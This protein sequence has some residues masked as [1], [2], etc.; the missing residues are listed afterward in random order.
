MMKKLIFLLFLIQTFAFGADLSHKKYLEDIDSLEEIFRYYCISYEAIQKSGRFDIDKKIQELR[1]RNVK[2]LNSDDFFS[3]LCGAFENIPDHHISFSFLGETYLLRRKELKTLGKTQPLLL[4][5]ER[6]LYFSFSDFDSE[7]SWKNVRK[8]ENLNMSDFDKI[9]FDLRGNSGGDFE[10]G[11]VILKKLCGL[12]YEDS[13]RFAIC[14]KCLLY[15]DSPYYSELKNM[16]E[17][18][19]KEMKKIEKGDVLLKRN[20]FSRN[21]LHINKSD[22]AFTGK[23]FVLLDGLTASSAEVFAILLRQNFKNIKLLGTE[24]FG[25]YSYGGVLPA[26]LPNS[27]IIINIP[28]FQTLPGVLQKDNLDPDDGIQPD[29]QTESIGA[30]LLALAE[31]G[32]SEEIIE[33]ISGNMKQT[34]IN[35]PNALAVAVVAVN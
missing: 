27:G 14:E 1:N 20:P 10:S 7:I 28:Q 22:S 5:K 26:I 29:F 12:E 23:I 24:S 16:L 25:A 32:I 6:E 9:I 17:F 15:G 34:L 18:S 35:L 11:A 2:I 3:I 33:M 19:K 31:D 4:E 13:D 21:Y 30:L 8:F